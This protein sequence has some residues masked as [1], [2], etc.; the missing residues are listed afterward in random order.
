MS[1]PEGATDPATAD[2]TPAG[3]SG[4]PRRDRAAARSFGRGVVLYSPTRRGGYYRIV[5]TRR[6]SRMVDTTAGRDRAAA[7]AK[8]RE[9]AGRLAA[10]TQAKS[11]R[12]QREMLAEF[13]GA[14]EWSPRYSR[15]IRNDLL[16]RLGRFLDQPVS[17]FDAEE[18][19][20]V[21]W[22]APTAAAGDHTK[23]H[24]SSLAS[25]A[26][27]QRWLTPEQA[28]M[29]RHASWRPPPGY[30]PPLARSS[31]PRAKSRPRRTQGEG[32]L[33]LARDLVPTAAQVN[34][35]AAA[36]GEQPH[37]REWGELW[38]QFSAHVG[39]QRISE[40]L[41]AEVGDL[42]R[43]VEEARVGAG[44]SQ[45]TLWWWR[46]DEQLCEIRPSGPASVAR[47]SGGPAREPCKGNKRREAPVPART[48]TGYPLRERLMQ[49]LDTVRDRGG[50]LLF[51]APRGGAWWQ[52]TFRRTVLNPALASAAWPIVCAGDDREA[53]WIRDWSSHAL[54]HFFAVCC[55]EFWKLEVA[56][57][58]QFGGWE[59]DAV[60]LE[61][62]Y[63]TS[64]DTSVQGALRMT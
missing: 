26:A 63:G 27:R 39:G 1:S 40:S 32:R 53:D 49:R 56:Q 5:V 15:T 16:L 31:S 8:A 4:G 62:Y 44:T 20:A 46:I 21:I 54:R 28:A 59:S 37:A 48:W 23:R 42:D 9:L 19:D 2:P 47:R 14:Q 35:L 22:S 18:I 57:T 64:R 45:Q 51:P 61:R 11:N 41:A 50:S 29:V 10:G 38:V 60:V 6:G 34:D 13:L 12:A 30:V 36:C 55:V 7:E 24:L 17:A 25:W 3:V 58:R 33:W 43:R 52:S